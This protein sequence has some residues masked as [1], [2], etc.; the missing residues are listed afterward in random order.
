ME[1]NLID[2]KNFKTARWSGGTTTEMFIFPSGASYAARD[3]IFRISVATAETERSVFTVLPQTERFITPLENVFKLTHKNADGEKE[4]LLYPMQ[5]DRFDGGA[6]TVCEGVGSDFNLMVKGAHGKMIC[7]S[8]GN[9]VFSGDYLFIYPLED[10]TVERNGEAFLKKGAL[11]LSTEKGK[12]KTSGA[13]VLVCVK[14]SEEK[15][16]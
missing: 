12:Y 15:A 5:V 13:C 7:F 9:V 14:L 16:Y 11:A 3:F 6:E 2:P 4:L 10:I 1:I 8:G